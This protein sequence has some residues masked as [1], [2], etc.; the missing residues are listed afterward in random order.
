MLQVHRSSVDIVYV[1]GVTASRDFPVAKPEQTVWKR[2]ASEELES[3]FFNGFVSAL[4]AVGTSLLL[5][6]YLGGSTGTQP[7][8]IATDATGN[9]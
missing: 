3:S 6:S 5:S 9:I 4:R 7:E 8:A 1:T 2:N